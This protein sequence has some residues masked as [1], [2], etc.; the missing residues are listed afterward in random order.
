MS[1]DLLGRLRIELSRMETRF[2]SGKW[3]DLEQEFQIIFC[4]LNSRHAMECGMT[5]AEWLDFEEDIK[6]G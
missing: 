6:N 2:Q 1:A 4:V 5:F 3:A